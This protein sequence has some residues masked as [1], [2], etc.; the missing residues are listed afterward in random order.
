[1]KIGDK[2]EWTS[3]SL[4]YEYKKSGIIRA[5]VPAGVHATPI[6]AALV[7]GINKDKKMTTAWPAAHPGS[8]R[9]HESYVVEVKNAIRGSR[10]YWPLVAHLR[11]IEKAKNTETVPC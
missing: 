10:L 11:V 5:V 7:V 9:K 6:I 8:P 4:S 2:V 1:M 3:Q